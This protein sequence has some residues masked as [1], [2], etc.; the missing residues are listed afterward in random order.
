MATR[1]NILLVTG[2]DFGRQLGCYGRGSAVSPRLDRLAA[3]GVR[4]D[5]AFATAPTCSPSRA[6]LHTGRYPHSAG[7]MG[8]PYDAQ[9]FRLTSNETHLAHLLRNAGYRTALVGFQHLVVPGREADLGFDEAWPDDVKD[10]AAVAATA[11]DFLR[12]QDAAQPFYL[13]LGF[14]QAHTDWASYPETGWAGEERSRGVTI[15]G[16][17]PATPAVESYLA[18]FQYGVRRL[19]EYVGTV[20]DALDQC[21]LAE[22]TW[23]VVAADHGMPVTR[24]KG[25]LYD[26]GIEVTLLMRYPG[27][28]LV[29]GRHVDAL[30]SNVDVVPTILDA[31]GAR[32]PDGVDGRSLL[33]LLTGDTAQVRT[34]V[35][36][37]Q[38]FC[39]DY[40]PM[41]CV[42]TDT[43]KLVY[44]AEAGYSI[45]YDQD[46]RLNP[47]HHDIQ[48]RYR[49]LRPHFELYD[50]TA[51]P[52]EQRDTYR[53][54]DARETAAD[55]R[56]RLRAW[57]EDTGDPLLDGPVPSPFYHR[58]VRELL[59]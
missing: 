56:R 4:F 18:A 39:D 14:F 11:V 10:G 45:S 16:F 50:L 48:M 52:D 28:G 9:G 53:C 8:F 35:F 5:N 29:G 37:E 12:R 30:V 20:L 13:E 59:S 42:R 21:G 36:A 23:V 38:T 41:R 49:Y 15:P 2:H 26:A 47:G 58:G 46:A 27:L 57:M 34:E 33:P 17:L 24:A 55:L 43:H 32:V 44:N 40:A 22:T 25:T 54:D 51:D 31:V 3:E 19:D 1:P 7:M 6:A